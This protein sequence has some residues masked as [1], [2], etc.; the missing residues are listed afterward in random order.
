MRSMVDKVQIEMRRTTSDAERAAARR[1]IEDLCRVH[2][3][4]VDEEGLARRIREE[5]QERRDGLQRLL[6]VE[7][8]RNRN[9]PGYGTVADTVAMLD[10]LLKVDP[11]PAELLGAI[12]HREDDLLD[13]AED[14]EDID[15]FFPDRQRIFDSATELL[16][17]VGADREDLET[18]AEAAGALAAIESILADKN[19][20]RRIS[21]LPSA[22]QQVRT[23][24]DRMLKAKRVDLLE[25]IDTTIDELA[26]YAQER[27]VKLSD[28]EK[29]RLARRDA[30]NN[31][32]TLTELDALRTRLEK[33]Q[34]RLS[35]EI[36]RE[37]DRI[38][39]PRPAT[40]GVTVTTEHGKTQTSRPDDGYPDDAVT[41]PTENPPT[42][43]TPPVPAPK[44]AT[45]ERTRIFK[46]R[47]LRSEQ[48]I[49]EY[50]ETARKQLL[51]ALAGNDSVKLN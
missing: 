14:L 25:Q 11:D 32:A 43:Q 5:L 46:P 31:A 49:D 47:R 19:I 45:I 37:Y 35:D 13:A 48:E 18:D 1:T 6:D 30:A 27:D 34:R 39:R 17:Q 23:V 40:T 42:K 38:N 20:Y 12:V 2:D 8:R 28:I 26:A 41:P 33:D 7:Y 21:E 29:T 9:Y 16:K 4:P 51:D 50:L 15:G 22:V 44:I 3:L 24:R 36:D 10:E